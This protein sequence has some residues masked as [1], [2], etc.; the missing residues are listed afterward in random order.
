MAWKFEGI[1]KKGKPLIFADSNG[2]L[3]TVPKFRDKIFLHMSPGVS[4]QIITR[5]TLRL[6]KMPQQEDICK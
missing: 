4:V 2:K 6:E 3:L 1:A 5:D